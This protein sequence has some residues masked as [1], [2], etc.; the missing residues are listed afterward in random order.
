MNKQEEAY[1]AWERRGKSAGDELS[2][3]LSVE[4]SRQ[5]ALAETPLLRWNVR[6]LRTIVLSISIV[7]GAI[8]WTLLLPGIIAYVD[9]VL[10]DDASFLNHLPVDAQLQIKAFQ[11]ENEQFRSNIEKIELALREELTRKPAV[12]AKEV[13]ELYRLWSTMKRDLEA[14]KPPISVIPFYL[15]PQMLLWP[16]IYSSLAILIFVIPPYFVERQSLLERIIKPLLLGFLIYFLYEWPLW[17]RNVFKTHG[18]KVYAYPNFDVDQGSFL[19]QELVILGFSV[20]LGFL[21]AQWT[22]FFK[23]AK[24][25][26]QKDDLC[27]DD[28]VRKAFDVRAASQISLLFTHWQFASLILAAG[29]FFF[30]QFFWNIVGRLND[31][32][33]LLSALVA[34]LLWGVS[35]VLITLPLIESWR[36]WNR[37][38]MEALRALA[39]EAHAGNVDAKTTLDLLREVQPVAWTNLI[40]TQ[41]AAGISFLLPLAQ[42]FLK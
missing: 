38:R 18:R 36:R 30:T 13:A 10:Y 34:H 35:W 9:G 40:L 11:H 3:W 12:N 1:Y 39:M 26:S 28:P 16:A 22:S 29:F 6:P 19:S 8:I 31:Q 14:S 42:V 27:Y 25:K 17:A 41:F 5:I 37:V 7:L 15:N 33:Y 2:D 23:I 21:W 20:L 32:R 4:Q 24:G